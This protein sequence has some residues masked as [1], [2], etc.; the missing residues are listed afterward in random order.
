[1]IVSLRSVQLLLFDPGKFMRSRKGFQ[2]AFRVDSL[3]LHRSWCQIIYRGRRLANE[4]RI[5]VK[6]KS[7]VR[8]H[9]N[10]LLLNVSCHRLR[11]ENL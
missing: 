1:M 6:P 11:A 3:A 2:P 8:V 7:V 9:R 5:G 10:F 4:L